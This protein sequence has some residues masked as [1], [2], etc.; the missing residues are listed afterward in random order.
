[1]NATNVTFTAFTKPWKTPIAE[2]GAFIKR[3]GFDGIELPVRPGYQVT[4]ENITTSLREATR[5]LAD[6]GLTITSIA[7]PTDEPT[8][9]ACAEVG[10]PIIRIC[11]DIPAQIS[12][13]EHEANLQRQF[14]A[15]LPHLERYGVTL[16]IQNHQGRFVANAMGIRHLIEKYDR[17]YIGAVLDFAHCALHGEI[18]EL[19]LDIVWS[20]LCMVNF[21]NAYWQRTNGPEALVATYKHY[22]TSGRQGLA[23]WARA[24]EELKQRGYSGPIC[25]TAEYTDEGAVNRL[26][27]EDI[28]YARSL[29]T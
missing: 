9:A 12:Y 20:H 5:I 27:A 6:C 14:D 4:P 7:G 13:L 26:I 10:V 1:M 29:F 17:R 18:P 23:S 15:L 8:I 24:A 22:W 21:K 28:T 16:G 25:L 19:A 3:L 11:L 2:L